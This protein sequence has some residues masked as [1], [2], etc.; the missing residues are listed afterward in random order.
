MISTEKQLQNCVYDNLKCLCGNTEGFDICD[1]DCSSFTCRRCIKS[2]YY[3]END[4]FEGHHPDCGNSLHSAFCHN[5]VDYTHHISN[6]VY[7]YIPEHKNGENI[8]KMFEH[9]K[10]QWTTKLFISKDTEF[11]IPRTY[12]DIIVG[13]YPEDEGEFVLYSE[14]QLDEKNLENRKT[15]IFKGNLFKNE[16][17]FF[18]CLIPYI[19][20]CF[21]TLV[22]KATCDCY[23]IT[24]VVD[25]E[26]RRDLAVRKWKIRDN[27]YIMLGKIETDLDK[28]NIK[29]MGFTLFEE[30]IHQLPYLPKYNLITKI[31]NLNNK[32]K[33]MKL[34]KEEKDKI[35]GD[36]DLL[37]IYMK[38]FLNA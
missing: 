34:T 32:N 37:S 25:L 21:E 29:C 5:K 24:S 1:N 26:L 28:L 11:K 3:I 8:L 13:I 10:K 6:L 9:K 7:E 17:N 12:M 27:L 15:D 30:H 2:Y 4:I 22:I 35:L 38:E 14:K 18:D 19:S 31:K 20:I 23:L 36:L 33:N 16:I